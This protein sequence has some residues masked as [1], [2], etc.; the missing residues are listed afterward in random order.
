MKIKDTDLDAFRELGNIGASNAV[1]ALS[2][3]LN[4]KVDLEIPPA[5]VLSLKELKSNYGTNKMSLGYSGTIK[6]LFESNL[7][8]YISNQ[9]ISSI[10]KV[11]METDEKKS[12][13]TLSDLSST[14]KSAIIE[15]LN[16]LIGQ[17]ISSIGNFLKTKIN[18]P[19]YQFFFKTMSDLLNGLDFSIKDKKIK[20]IIMETGINIEDEKPIK[21]VFMLF[22]RPATIHRTLKRISEIW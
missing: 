14:E 4:K 11:I 13:N 17:Y 18:P 1:S 6:G 5:K 22:L 8:L 12:I 2:Q 21:G 9:D 7:L 19:E 10:L 3:M 16:I 20:T 15:L